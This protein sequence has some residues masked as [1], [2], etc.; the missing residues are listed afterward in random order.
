MYAIWMDLRFAW[1]RLRRRGAYTATASIILALGI[2]VSVALFSVLEGVL[3]SGL[4]Y[5]GGTRVV[6]VA[7]HNPAHDDSFARLTAAEAERLAANG[8]VFESFGF[9]NW[10]GMTVLDAGRPREVTFNFVSPGFFAALG[11]PALHGRVLDA[12]DTDG[13]AVVVLS[14]SE[15]QRMGGADAQL[16]GSVIDTATDGPLRVIGVMPPAFDY[17]VADVGAWR[18]Y[19]RAQLR[20]DTPGYRNARFLDAVGRFPDG[21]AAAVSRDR[22][23]AVVDA[24]RHD[25]GQPDAGWRIT[26]TP[27]LEERVGPLQPALWASFGIA[28]LVL[29]IACANVAILV[30]AQQI[31]QRHEQAL[32]QALGGSRRRMF[33]SLL[34]ELLLL[35]LLGAALGVALAAAGLD[36]FRRLADGT[37]PRAQEIGL[38]ARVLLFALVLAT[39]TPLLAVLAGSLRPRSRALDAMRG[40][41]RGLVGRGGAGAR[42]MPVF[43][44]TLSTVGLVAAAAMFANLTQTRHV[45]PGFDAGQ[46]HALQLFRS[47][48]AGDWA[49]FANTLRGRLAA[50]PGVE[51]V[52]VT[53]AAPLS[54]IGQLMIEMRMPGRA[55]P[56]PV[57]ASVRRVSPG[58][59]QLLQIPLLS[60]RDISDV[61]RAGGEPVAVVNQALVRQVFGGRDALGELIAVP[62]GR[63]GW[64]EHRIVGIS[65]DIRNAGL[66]N[67]PVPEILVPFEQMPWVGMTFLV[68]S[69]GEVQGMP[70]LLREAL[71]QVDPLQATT[72]EFALA[73]D[74][75]SELAIARFFAGTLGALALCALL[76]AAL[77]VYA[78]AAQQQVQRR[79][80]LGLRLAV[81]APPMRLARL[82]FAGSLGM[83]LLGIAIGVS[84]GGLGLF[85]LSAHLFGFG[86]AY[87]PWLAMAVACMV[88]A[89][90]LAAAPSAWRAW[91]TDPASVLRQA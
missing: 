51:R 29:L 82:V 34:L 85:V 30:D 25:H 56:E 67:A 32:V 69:V 31:A 35:S 68:R 11:V 39:L 10:A 83:S 7:L 19:P 27:L 50:L 21:M 60:G 18:P 61:D 66:Q 45:E 42:A 13:D 36:V 2:A 74:L 54:S 79:P 48:G 71:W 91:R 5:P 84:L 40:G 80:E 3:L 90:L 41:G 64:V 44:V 72:R 33:R 8:E 59:L 37:V 49:G 20:P 89:T 78:V 52:A 86:I 12:S 73:D 55:E 81:G 9:Y 76:L 17:P 58:Y 6:A 77:G 88:V 15:W 65:A 75:A 24:V 63:E 26:A 47:P 57:Q 43:G 38:N 87:L 23:Q 70:A 1:S 28:L 46:V 16:L 22:M 4:P 62:L 14:H 53:S